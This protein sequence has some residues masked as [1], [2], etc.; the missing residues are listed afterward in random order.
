MADRCALLD[1]YVVCTKVTLL[2]RSGSLSRR[3]LC[4][5]LRA[6]CSTILHCGTRLIA[7]LKTL[8]PALLNL[9]LPLLNTSHLC[10]YRYSA[11]R[12][13]S[14]LTLIMIKVWF[15]I[16]FRP[17][18]DRMLTC[19]AAAAAACSYSDEHDD[20]TRWMAAHFS[21]YLWLTGPVI[22]CWP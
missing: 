14:L 13:G 8:P 10:G 6:T 16:V 20:D 21:W 3:P 7:R 15:G 4:H 9:R 11:A 2:C 19:A 18:P 17:V 22:L 1:S 5:M 12:V